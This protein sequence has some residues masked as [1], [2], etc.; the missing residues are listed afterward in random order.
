MTTSQLNRLGDRL[1]RNIPIEPDDLEQLQA[2]RAEYFLPAREVQRV[3]RETTGHAATSRVKTDKTIIDKL[4]RDKT[5]LSTMH[6]IAGV[7][8][9]AEVTLREQRDLANELLGT[10]GGAQLVD[11]MTEPR[12]GYRAL[13][14]IARH[15]GFPV[16]IQVRTTLQHLWAEALEKM[17]DIWGRGVR[18]GEIPV[19]RGE[20]GEVVTPS[21]VEL[22]Q[23]LSPVIAE[24]EERLQ[25]FSEMRQLSSLLDETALSD[26]NA[27]SEDAAAKVRRFRQTESEQADLHKQFRTRISRLLDDIVAM[28]PSDVE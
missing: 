22:L 28:L 20:D 23:R 7:R 10:F 19:F 5:R 25:G 12:F 8:V 11:R 17:S 6:D 1:R 26:L 4:I 18:Y 14:V 27:Q 13:H 21:P 24:Y 9:I 3:I 15:D 2:I 16:E